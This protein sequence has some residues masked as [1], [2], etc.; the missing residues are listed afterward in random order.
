MRL[1]GRVRYEQGKGH[2]E[3]RQEKARE[4]SDGKAGRK[5]GKESEQTLSRLKPPRNELPH[6][7]RDSGDAQKL[8]PPERNWHL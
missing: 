8:R 6:P 7:I 1:S 3:R 4:E 2:E 5:K